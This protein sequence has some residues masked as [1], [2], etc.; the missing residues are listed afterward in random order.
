VLVGI[1][2]AVIVSAATLGG[3]LLLLLHPERMVA[4]QE[5][6]AERV[7]TVAPSENPEYYEETRGDRRETFRFGGF[8][9]TV[10]GLSLLGVITYGLLH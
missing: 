4:Y 10:A 3:G 9:M 1:A 7:A 8:V 6:Y 2:L 5:R